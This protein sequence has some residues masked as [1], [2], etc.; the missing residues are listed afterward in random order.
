MP[1][2]I[3]IPAH[4]NASEVLGV[5]EN[6]NKKISATPSKKGFNI[7]DVRTANRCF[8]SVCFSTQYS[9][10]TIIRVDIIITYLGQFAKSDCLQLCFCLVDRHSIWDV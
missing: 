6:E 2:S 1:T 5:E 9:Y 10:I 4:L 8:I 3:E 7:F